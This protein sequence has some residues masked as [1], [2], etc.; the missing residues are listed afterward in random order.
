MVCL[1]IKLFSYSDIY[2]FIKWPRLWVRRKKERN[3]EEVQSDWDKLILAN[4]ENPAFNLVK[5][6]QVAFY[7]DWN[8]KT[9]FY[10]KFKAPM[11]INGAMVNKMSADIDYM[12]TKQSY[13]GLRDTIHMRNRK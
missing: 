6:K 3:M 10:L 8:P 13:W 12:Q 1:L 11:K 9:I 4:R 5:S 7:Y 2:S